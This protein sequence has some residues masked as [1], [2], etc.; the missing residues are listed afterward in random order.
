MRCGKTA[1]GQPGQILPTHGARKAPQQPF[2]ARN[3]DTRRW[4]HLAVQGIYL[5]RTSAARR[6][7]QLHHPDATILLLFDTGSAAAPQPLLPAST[8][9]GLLLGHTDSTLSTRLVVQSSFS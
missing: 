8:I 1:P 4:F 3:Q 7:P 6:H 5:S 2:R 9:A